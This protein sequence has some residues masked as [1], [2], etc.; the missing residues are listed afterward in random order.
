ML[1]MRKNT[2]EQ[3]TLS[4]LLLSTMLLSQSAWCQTATEQAAKKST[5]DKPTYSSPIALSNDNQL[6]WSVNPDSDSVSVIRTDTNTLI[7]T[8][9]VGDEPRSITLSPNNRY[10]WVANAAGNSVTVIKIKKGKPNNFKAVVTKQAMVTGAEPNGIVIS[11][12][13]K[14]V[15]VA[16]SNQ[17][18]LTVINAKN[19][20]IIGS[21]DLKNSLC[22]VGDKQRHFHPRALAVTQDNKQL[23][24]TRF[25]SYTHQTGA[26]KEDSGKE[27]VVCRL[28]I[29][30]HSKSI[31]DYQ[32]ASVVQ[33]SSTNTGMLDANGQ[34]TSAF[35]NQMQSIVLRDGHAYLPNIAASPSGPQR[36]D[37][38]TQAYVNRIDGIGSNET[39]AGSINLHLGGAEPEAGKLELYFA[40]P[41]GMAFTNQSGPGSAYVITA[42]SDMLVKLNVAVNGE[43]AFT[44]DGDT[45]RYIDLNDP[46]N[47]ATSGANAGKNPLGI[48]INDAGTTAYVT[49][50]ISRNVSVVDLTSDT[51]VKVVATTD[52]PAPGSQDEI[53]LVG[54]EMFYSSRGN[55]VRPAGAKGSSRNRLG[56]KARQGC[57]SCHARGLTDG[58]I[59]QFASGPRKTLAV[60]GTFNPKDFSDQ[61]IINASAVFDEVEDADLNTRR[62]SSSGKLSVPLPC[63][64]L[65]P[66]LGVTEGTNNRD[67]G[68]I[69]GE[70]GDFEFAPCTI[71]QF[72]KPNAGRPQPDV[73][74]P[75]SNVKVPAHD[76]LIDYQRRALRTPN[77]AMTVAEL[78]HAGAPTVGGVIGADIDAGEVLFVAANCQSCHNG[79]KWTKS[80]KDFVSPPDP[81]EVFSEVGAVGANQ[82][83]FLARFLN[84]IG[85]YNLNVAGQGNTI[86][87][88]PAIGGMEIDSGGNKALGID[89]NGDGKGNG[90]NAATI[91]GAFSSP[92]YYHNGACETIACVMAD[93]NHRRA[94]LAQ[95]QADPLDDANARAK[96]VT[97]VESIDEATAVH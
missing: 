36:F 96:V 18:T 38:N 66:L 56:E 39:D 11:P 24:V 68:L 63:N 73:L 20:K 46:D 55:F 8:I 45:T 37:V 94:G 3:A 87:G 6:I 72:A 12:D 84:D 91:L 71:N 92:P 26:Q 95:G 90:F 51:V 5:F 65:P 19:R 25:L 22:N 62:V 30:T 9:D 78:Q 77:R 7:A 80:H 93:V 27:G 1:S 81:S 76:A 52:L 89:H 4:A 40:N 85:S 35:P 49:N 67:H 16:N 69:L 47:S 2:A 33:M 54:A 10:A 15:F 29:D 64:E 57:A 48:V 75:G 42:G 83:Q 74:L 21:V 34:A 79:G 60:N 86:S 44:V 70:D 58:V 50:Y 82:F 23:Y 28:D 41:W 59:W 53:N 88:Y 31:G 13:G 17:D 14:R 32:P 97:Y 43:L 61:K